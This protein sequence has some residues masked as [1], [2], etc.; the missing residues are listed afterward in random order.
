MYSSNTRFG[1]GDGDNQPGEADIRRN[2]LG[3]QHLVK[4]LRA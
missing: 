1:S 4:L 3:D 2:R